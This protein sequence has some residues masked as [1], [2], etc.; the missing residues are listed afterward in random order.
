MKKARYFLVALIPVMALATAFTF[1]HITS[2][3]AD[4][5]SCTQTG[6]FRDNI[7]LTAALIDPVGTV[8]GPVNATGC[9]IGIYYDGN[10]VSGAVKGAEIYGANYFG[11]VN[12]GTKLSITKSKIHDIGESPFNGTQHGVAIYFAYGSASSGSISNN[13]IWN[14]QKGGIVVNGV[15]ASAAITSNTVLGFGPVTFIAQNGIQIGYGAKATVTKNY[16]SGNAYSGTNDAAS[17]GI[18][19]VGGACYSDSLTI[20]TKIT[21]NT[22]RGNDVGVYLSNLDVDPNTSQC[23]PTLTP[24]KIVVNNDIST[25]DAV[26]NVSGC[27]Y[28]C[29]YQ[30]GISDQ[31]DKDQ[32]TNNQTCGVGYTPVQSP[33]PYLYGIDDTATN[34]PIESGNTTCSYADTHPSQHVKHPHLVK[35]SVYAR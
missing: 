10:V 30:A 6:F 13:L 35:A 2:A 29:G 5:P 12:N 25:N 33:P 22:L 17:G 19:V 32:M 21:N 11:I 24:T 9:N 4:N 15:N 34:N 8:K 3:K 18:L 16:V 14:Y 20:G 23:V 27:G 26:T 7:N 31:G 1:F 28:P